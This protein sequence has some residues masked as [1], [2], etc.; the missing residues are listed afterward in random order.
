MRMLAASGRT[1]TE[2]DV[3]KFLGVIACSTLALGAAVAVP[4]A[5]SAVDL[6]C[7]SQGGPIVTRVDGKTACAA[8][9]APGSTATAYGLDGV[10]F[11]KARDGARAIGVGMNGGIGAS[12]GGVGTPAAIGVG[13]G[14]IAITSV[15]NGT[16]SVALAL[17]GSQ[18]LVGDVPDGV[19]C[20][21]SSALAINLLTG[22]ACVATGF[23]A[24]QTP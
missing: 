5:A 8:D 15:R 2:G 1:A 12:E 23:G 20:Q 9:A 3:L 4:G 10:G 16:L 6:D 18:A 21:G 22:R 11:A 17:A 24:W 7:R 14:S 19:V 13:P